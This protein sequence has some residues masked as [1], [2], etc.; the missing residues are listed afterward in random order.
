LR[1]L[2]N[3]NADSKFVPF[4][5]AGFFHEPARPLRGG[6]KFIFRIV[7]CDSSRGVVFRSAACRSDFDSTSH[8]AQDLDQSLLRGSKFDKPAKNDAAGR[9]NV[10]RGDP[11]R[12]EPS[13]AESQ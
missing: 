4:L 9:R 8:A 13:A 7:K 12:N 5:T 6:P 1:D 3:H 10:P 2:W 11:V